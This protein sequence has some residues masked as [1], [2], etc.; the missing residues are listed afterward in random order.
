MEDRT[1]YKDLLELLAAAVAPSEEESLQRFN[2]W[3]EKGNFDLHFS[4][5]EF[6]FLPFLWQRH[7]KNLPQN[8]IFHKVQGLFKR[9][10]FHNTQQLITAVALTKELD[11]VKIKHAY[12]KGLVF[13]LQ[14]YDNLGSRP[15]A[16]IDLLVAEK[17]LDRTAQVLQKLGFNPSR[18]L[19]ESGLVKKHSLGFTNAKN[20]S[21][22]LHTRPCPSPLI[23]FDADYFLTDASR[24]ESKFGPIP[25]LQTQKALQ[26]SYLN[27]LYS[28]ENHWLLDMHLAD[29]HQ[30]SLDSF[31]KSLENAPILKNILL[32]RL[33]NL[34][35]FSNLPAFHSERLPQQYQ[36]FMAN[37]F[38][39]KPT[40][41]Y[42]NHLFW[43]YGF[44]GEAVQKPR[45]CLA[46]WLRMGL[47]S[48]S[49]S[50]RRL[51]PI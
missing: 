28:R 6:R 32:F 4:A 7:K 5:S 50:L 29:P 1:G 3:L 23:A 38:Q 13:L 40:R 47:Y 14:Y 24:F 49:W 33:Q 43:Y 44:N 21:I 16:D 8:D 20:L 15:M 17:D 27:N 41:T 37:Q 45:L 46:Y 11:Q 39:D 18:P 19:W 36:T 51:N 10:H 30:K 42:A 9:T 2:T 34:P 26:F 35:E 22:D 31:L 25:L 48:L 12:C